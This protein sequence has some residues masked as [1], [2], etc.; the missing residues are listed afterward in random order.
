MDKESAERKFKTALEQQEPAFEKFFLARFFDLQIFY[1]DETCIVEVDVN[2]Y[3]FNPQGSLHG[4]VISFILD[5]S[6]GHLCHEFSA[7]A[8]T[9]EMK[10]QYLKAVKSGK[11][12]CEARF[13]KKGKTLVYIE[14][15]MM[16]ENGVLIAV[17]T[18]TWYR[19]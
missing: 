12:R 16:D 7:T 10:T 9:L 1:G 2:D 14:S 6:M 11:V 15:K 5:V 8:V 3:M 4:G 13:L 18:A 17:A 19:L